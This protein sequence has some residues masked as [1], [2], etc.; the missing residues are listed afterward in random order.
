MSAAMDAAY[1]IRVDPVLV[2]ASYWGVA[3]G[4]V[5][6]VVAVAACLALWLTSALGSS[7]GL[8]ATISLGSLLVTSFATISW[9]MR[10]GSAVEPGVMAVLFSFM[11]AG[12]AIVTGVLTGEMI[13]SASRSVP[14]DRA[15]PARRRRGASRVESEHAVEELAAQA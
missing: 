5:I 13:G 2:T 14:H 15:I 11:A 9:A 6:G 8:S 7:R 3:A 12:V 4:A 1:L 10:D